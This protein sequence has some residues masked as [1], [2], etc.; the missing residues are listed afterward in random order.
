MRIVFIGSVQFSARMLETLIEMKTDVV[1]ICTLPEASFNADYFDLTEIADAVGIAVRYTPDINAKESI[2]WIASLSPDVIFCFGWSR[3]IR[4]PLL[5]LAPLGVIGYHPAALPENRG[6]HPLIWALAL[7]MRE[8]AS[9]F[10]FMDEGA[11][12]GDIISQKSLEIHEADDAGTLYQ[13]MVDVAAIQIME[14]VPALENGHYS[15]APQNAYQAN[16]WRKRSRLDGQID[17]R[18]PA[19]SIH[20]LVRALSPP[21][22]GAH[23]MHAGQEIKAWRT[24]VVTEPRS[25]L[26]PGKILSIDDG[27]IIKAGSDAVRLVRIEPTINLRAGEYI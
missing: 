6:R 19:C 8:T 12:S 11:D 22:L 23:F 3:L 15:R 17:W 21:Y 20:N 13:R 2:E 7:G 26:E 16:Y 10:F 18:M 24:E 4:E 25:N 1:G 27:I 14:F 9:T 5:H